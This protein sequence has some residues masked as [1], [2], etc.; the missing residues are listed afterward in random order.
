MQRSRLI[1]AGAAL[2]AVLLTGCTTTPQQ[3]SGGEGEGATLS[4]L[5]PWTQAQTQ[6]MLD[7]YA[8]EH[9]EVTIN[10]TYVAGNEN[11]QQL[12]TTQLA[13]GNAPDVFYL[14]PGAGSP[15]SVG[16]LAEAGYLRDL[17]Q[18]SWAGELTDPYRTFLSH[19]GAVY[20]YPSTVFG[21]GAIYNEAKLSEAGLAAPQTWSELIKFCGDA[22]KN[23]SPAFTLGA[24]ATW[25]NAVIPYALAATLVDSK[26]PDFEAQVG[27]STDFTDSEWVTALAKYQEMIDAGCFQE[28]PTGTDGPTTWKN[29]GKGDS[30]GVVAPGSLL[31]E[32]EANAPEGSTWR[33]AAL[34]A[35]DDAQE[36]AMPVSLSSTV[37][38]NAKSKQPEATMAFV[39]WLAAPEQL[40]RLAELQAG[41]VPTIPNDTFE[42]PESIA[43]VQEM[44]EAERATP[45][46]DLAWPNPQVQAALQ[47]GS[48]AMLLGQSNPEQVTKDMQAAARK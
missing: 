26:N 17:S 39:N 31:S 20:A 15:T 28:N 10:V 16:V 13:A 41:A 44:Q 37:G 36:T 30:F 8:E 1:M 11:A 46:P 18:E 9:P 14:N 32:I 27:T 12:L 23:G 2:A 4:F 45:V 24:G 7:A 42:V 29:V 34:P 3:P 48:Q 25:I 22:T 21:I 40:A 43:V 47:S 5:S 33:M 6:P 35:T 19:D 38:V